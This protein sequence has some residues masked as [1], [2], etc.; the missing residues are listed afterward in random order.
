MNETIVTIGMHNNSTKDP[1]TKASD[2]LKAIDKMAWNKHRKEYPY[3]NES[4]L[5]IQT[6][7]VPGATGKPTFYLLSRVL[8][9]GQSQVCNFS[10]R[11]RAIISNLKILNW[12]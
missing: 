1:A 7:F 11:L 10:V 9:R 3:H 12:I 2:A 4:D 8:S 6:E 5:E